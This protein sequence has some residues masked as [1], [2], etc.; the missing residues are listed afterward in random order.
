MGEKV[1][2]VTKDMTLAYYDESL[3]HVLGTPMMIFLMEVAAGESMQEFLPEGH[4]SVGV[5]VNIRHLA[6]TPVGD[7]VTAKSKVIEV[8]DNLVKFE[9]E[10]HDSAHLIGSGF[11]TRAV[12]ELE[13]FV[14][15]IERRIRQLESQRQTS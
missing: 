2:E 8:V 11:H 12:L 15:K 10:A 6:A 1:A 14:R 7:I 3:P 4:I 5:E 9:V 13:R